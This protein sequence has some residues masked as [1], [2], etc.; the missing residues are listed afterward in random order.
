[1][2][3]QTGVTGLCCTRG[4]MD[5]VRSLTSLSL[6]LSPIILGQ[7]FALWVVSRSRFPC[8]LSL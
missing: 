7:S 3:L 4:L 1:M 8:D 5:W 2:D 6:S